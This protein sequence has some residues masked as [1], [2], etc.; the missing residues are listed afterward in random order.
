MV[1][2]LLFHGKVIVLYFL[3]HGKKTEISVVKEL[4]KYNR[5]IISKENNYKDVF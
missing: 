3:G 5:Q 1:I 4:Q 2:F